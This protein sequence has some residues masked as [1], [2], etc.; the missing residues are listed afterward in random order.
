MKQLYRTYNESCELFKN[1]KL[2]YPNLIDIEVIGKTWEKRD[3]LLIKL[4][5]DV[6]NSDDKPALF[7]TGTIHARE[8]IGHELAIEFIKYVIENIHYDHRLDNIFTES[9]I[10]LVPCANPDGFV[11]SQEHFSFWRKNRRKNIDGSFGVDLNR[12]FSIGFSKGK[13][14]DSNIYSGDKPFSEPET[15][16]LKNFVDSHPNISIALDY[17]SQGNVFF[18]AHDFRHEDTID[19]TDMNILCAN[20]AEEIRKVSNREYG[21]HQ[22]K[23]PS[24][25]IS[26][27]GREYYYS[28]GIISTVVEVGSRNI[29]DYLDNMS[30]NIKE[31]IKALLVALE[32]VK[33]Y[34]QKYRIEAVKNFQVVEVT[35]N[36]VKL[37]WDY[38][39]KESIY[40]EI[41]RNYK[42]KKYCQESNLIATTQSL[43]FVDTNL[44]SSKN[45]FYNIRVVDNNLNIK[46]SYTPQIQI[47]TVVEKDE[48]SR[49]LYPNPSDIGYVA[50]KIDDEN[51]QKHFGLNSLFVGIDKKR[52][53]SYGVLSFNLDTIPK[54]IIIKEARVLLYPMN[55]VS[56]TIEKYGEWNISLLNNLNSS[57]SFKSFNNIH[58]ADIITRIG[59]A[60]KSNHLTQGIWREWKCSN[61]EAK[62]IEKI[63]N[64]EN[65]KII[66]RVDGPDSLKLGRDSQ[67]MQWDIGYNKFS[68]GLEYRPQLE[69]LYSLKPSIA[70]IKTSQVLTISKSK[71]SVNSID[72]QKLYTGFDKNSNLIYSIIRFNLNDFQKNLNKNKI[73]L[74]KAYIKISSTK[75][76]AKDNIRFHLEMIEPNSDYAL[77]L[78]YT[79]IKNRDIIEKIGYDINSS[80]IKDS[81]E[82]IFIFDTFSLDELQKRVD[83]E[84]TFVIRASSNNISLKNRGV[85]WNIKDEVLSPKLIIEYIEKPLNNNLEVTNL[86]YSL[87]SHNKILLQWDNPKSDDFKGV[88]VIK[89][90][91]R[92]PQNPFDGQKLYGGKDNYTIDSF[93]AIDIDKYYAVFTYD[94]VPNYS[95]GENIKFEKY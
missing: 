83:K 51:N 77:N 40:F 7:Y 48:F 50:E 1:Y 91:F 76:Y 85:E 89:N 37:S 52:G 62:E 65:S 17:H 41:Y 79:M 8:W 54:N 30:E 93:G 14:L 53:I 44:E 6:T 25:L 34:S 35:S 13:S 26:G 66:F 10:Y 38:K 74:T 39:L 82:Q 86:R 2:K 71:N 70:T 27:S 78:N 9:V 68:L 72:N 49:I 45:Y 3:I 33:N 24:S 11:Y 28:K 4:S 64:S 80:D 61:Y 43:H 31:N 55:R 56:T 67:M 36:S 46:S 22:G 90:P 42:D 20:M 63:L 59:E 18:P 16:A 47:K 95:K 5:K 12:N 15:K 58:N 60:T 84:V 73:S 29:S 81:K 32:E 88:R 87:N 75:V 19:T 92:V 69:I 94:E 57:K 23:P 21:I